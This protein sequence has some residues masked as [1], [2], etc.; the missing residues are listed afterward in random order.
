MKSL[1]I[2]LSL[3]LPLAGCSISSSF[4]DAELV[5]TWRRGAEGAPIEELEIFPDGTYRRSGELDAGGGFTRRGTVHVADGLMTLGYDF[6]RERAD[7]LVHEVGETTAPYAVAEDLLCF[8]GCVPFFESDAGTFR[9]S[10]YRRERVRT[11]DESG[12]RASR[13]SEE[14][15]TWELVLRGDGECLF[16]TGSSLRRTTEGSV[17]DEGPYGDETRP[18]TY[19]YDEGSGDEA[20]DR[21]VIEVPG[22]PELSFSLIPFGLG[23]IEAEARDG[24]YERVA[25]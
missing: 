19:V 3:A 6:I 13:G 7:L 25:Q 18:C 12:G 4:F 23:W 2:V 17:T 8:D 14:L 1:S 10:R 22:D 24:R 15:E 20:D 21:Y 16:V 11:T 5:G 9:R